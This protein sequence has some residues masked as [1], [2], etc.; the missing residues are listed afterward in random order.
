MQYVAGFLTSF[1]DITPTGLAA[2]GLL[3]ALVA[4]IGMVW[5]VHRLGP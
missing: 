4:V 2:L 5:V 1:L 3:V